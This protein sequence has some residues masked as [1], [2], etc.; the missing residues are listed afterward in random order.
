MKKDEVTAIRLPLPI[1]LLTKFDQFC[2]EHDYNRVEGIRQAIREMLE[3]F[4]G[5][6]R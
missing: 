1:K 4:E 2:E 3:N 6:S 5:D